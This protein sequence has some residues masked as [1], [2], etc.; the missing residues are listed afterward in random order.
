MAAV[1]QDCGFKAVRLK[2]IQHNNDITDRILS[3]IRLAG[4]MIA[5]F[6]QHKSGVYYEAGFARALGREV[7]MSCREDDFE[8][9]HFDTNHLNHIKWTT[10]TDLR[11][12]L[13]DRIRAT[14]LPKA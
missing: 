9:L 12:K 6:T 8:K 10:P 3:E 14:I 7:I 5:D 13:A 4:F 11:E 2:E 1:E